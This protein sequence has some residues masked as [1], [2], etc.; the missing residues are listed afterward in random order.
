[1]NAGKIDSKAHTKQSVQ[2]EFRKSSNFIEINHGP[3]L[4]GCG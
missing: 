3:L 1:M 2:S 4:D